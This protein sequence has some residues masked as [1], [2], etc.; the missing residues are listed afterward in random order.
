MFL[1]LWSTVFF[2]LFFI[3]VCLM[4]F[5]SNFPKY[6]SFS[7]SPSV[8]ILF[9]F[10]SLIPSIISLFPLFIMRRAQFSMS[11]SIPLSW[12]YILIVLLRSPVLFPFWQIAWH[13]LCTF[14]NK[15][16]ALLSAPK[17]PLSSLHPRHIC[18]LYVWFFFF[19]LRSLLANIFLSHWLSPFKEMC[20]S[21]KIN[22]LY[23]T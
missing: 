4:V 17:N 6:L 7:F 13:Y 20:S 9:W 11:N 22:I 8:L 19:F 2:I 14:S 5:D 16:S 15:F 1:F 18:I 10:S 21:A 12:L 3:L 23:F